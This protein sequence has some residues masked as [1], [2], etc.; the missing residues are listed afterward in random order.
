MDTYNHLPSNQTLSHL[1]HDKWGGAPAFSF[2]LCTLD[3][4]DKI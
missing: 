1:M 4:F 2:L 3:Q